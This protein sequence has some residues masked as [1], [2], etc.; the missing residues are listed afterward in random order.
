MLLQTSLPRGAAAPAYAIPVY[1]QRFLTIPRIASLSF[2]LADGRQHLTPVKA[3]YDLAEPTAYVLVDRRSVKA[4]SLH[5]RSAR[6]AIGECDDDRWITVEGRA[7]VS[8]DIH[9]V[10]RARAL[11]RERFGRPSRWGDAVVAVEVERVL[12][13]R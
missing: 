9:L 7:S 13:G 2:A 4:R 3:T 6:V 12:G 10:E 8:T 11:Y 5:D 1:Y